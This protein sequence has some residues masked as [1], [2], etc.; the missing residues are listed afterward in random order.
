MRHNPIVEG[1]WLVHPHK[2]LHLRLQGTH[3]RSAAGSSPIALLCYIHLATI[4]IAKVPTGRHGNIPNCIPRFFERWLGLPHRNRV[5]IQPPYLETYDVAGLVK[6]LPIRLSFVEPVH[7]NDQSSETSHTLSFICAT[8]E[9]FDLSYL[10]WTPTSLPQ[11][12]L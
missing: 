5:S 9:T 7:A 3:K 2:L 8:L 6:A 10:P 11:S 4:W 1:L 12:C